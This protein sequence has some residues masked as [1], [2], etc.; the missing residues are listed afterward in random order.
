MKHVFTDISTI[1]HMWANKVQDD[2]RNP[3]NNFYY[4]KDTIYSYG[5]H[6]PIAKHIV[7]N[8]VSAI[9]FTERTYSNTTAKHIQVVRQAANHLNVIY[10]F[11]PESTH[12]DNLN[13]WLV[14]AENIVANLTT[15]R[16]PEIYL[17]KIGDIAN[18]V[19]KYAKYFGLTIPAV[20]VAVLAIANKSQYAEYAGKKAELE[21][22]AAKEAE[23]KLKKRHK[24]ELS[25]WL[26]GKTNRL[27]V[28]NGHD[29][30]RLNNDNVETT[31]AVK[32]P[33]D[34]ARKIYSKIAA[35]KLVVGD[36]ILS[37][38]VSEVG[39]D[40]KVGCHTFETKYLLEFGKKYLLVS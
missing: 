37:Y 2:A 21:A 7:N 25:Q 20:L 32:L 35:N 28:H 24:K 12:T 40:I 22:I 29:Y 39:K 15:A 30:L 18:R 16:K 10:C 38:E 4:D 3:T 5:R 19:N 36:K 6:F 27:Y 14:S 8:G 1:A 31:Q 23:V 11:N 34:V 33:V 17:S 9:L 26:K 13:S